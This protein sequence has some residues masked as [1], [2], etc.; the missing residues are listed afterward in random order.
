MIRAY[1]FVALIAILTGCQPKENREQ[2]KAINLSLEK[3]NE[4]IKGAS[5]RALEQ[6]KNNHHDDPNSDRIVK[7]LLIMKKVKAETD[8]LANLIENVKVE[9]LKQSD[10]LK[11][12]NA[13]I[14]HSLHEPN[15]KGYSLMNKLASFKDNI[16][17]LF[18]ITDSI[19]TPF[20]YQT[21]KANIE[22]LR[23]TSPLFPDYGISMNEEQRAGYLNKWLDNNLHGSSALMS[24]VILNK[25]ENDVLY[26]GTYLMDYCNSQIY[27]LDGRASYEKFNAVAFLS[28]SYVKRGQTI[29]VTA[30]AGAFG[31]AANPRVSI[32]E[33]EITLDRGGVALYKFKATGKPG[34]HS[35]PVKIA[36]KKINGFTD[37]LTKKLEYEIA[38]EK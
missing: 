7:L 30:G 9:L 37:T 34:K 10:N 13:A 25:L 36:F 5:E 6:M 20:L 32:D 35:I 14:L 29:E 22:K 23:K 16:P 27:Y 1:F 4:L 31:F 38:D 24:M 21:V 17:A 15:G 19:N 3:S 33:R 28:S 26:T 11:V 2:L 8:T 18:N 12:D